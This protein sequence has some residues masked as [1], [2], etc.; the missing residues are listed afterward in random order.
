MPRSCADRRRAPDHEI[1][2]LRDELEQHEGP[3]VTF[4]DYLSIAP[5]ASQ[6]DIGRALRKLAK[7]MHPDKAKASALAAHAKQVSASARS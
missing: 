1:F 6:E 7:S 4:Y 2:R 5:S 3:N